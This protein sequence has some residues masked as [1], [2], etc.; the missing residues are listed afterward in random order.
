MT[1]LG[2]PPA[3]PDP[4]GDRYQYEA[5]NRKGTKESKES[6]LEESDP[7]WVDLRH[8]FIA[9]VSIKLNNLLTQFREQN[10]AAKV[11]PTAP[12]SRSGIQLCG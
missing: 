4:P 3:S 2:G 12:R 10:K 5:E 7:M 6:L 8:M 9:D 1:G 11:A